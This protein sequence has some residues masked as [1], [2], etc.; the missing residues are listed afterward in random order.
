[1]SMSIFLMITAV[2]H[3]PAPRNRSNRKTYRTDRTETYPGGGAPVP[4]GPP[5]PATS[6]TWRRL[7][8]MHVDSASRKTRRADPHAKKS[9]HRL[10]ARKKKKNPSFPICA[11]KL[12]FCM[13]YPVFEE[14]GFFGRHGQIVHEISLRAI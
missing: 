8:G 6:R 3:R 1:M 13:F 4:P 5:Y 10:P 12:V 14:L 2:Q 7:S 11:F 9:P